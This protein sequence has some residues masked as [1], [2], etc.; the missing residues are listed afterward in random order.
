[1]RSLTAD[2]RIFKVWVKAAVL[3][4]DT[5]F[6]RGIYLVSRRTGKV[7]QSFVPE[8]RRQKI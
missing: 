1:M 5:G 6:Y 4:G 8:K 3:S 2:R 7:I